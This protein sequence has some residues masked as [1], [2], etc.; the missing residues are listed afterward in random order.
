[1]NYRVLLWNM[2]AV[3]ALALGCYVHGMMSKGSHL[4]SPGLIAWMAFGG[5]SAMLAAAQLL[6]AIF[7]VVKGRPSARSWLLCGLIT[8]AVGP[9]MCG[10]ARL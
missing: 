3:V 10:V 9:G 1:M 5:Y 7:L 6:V 8:A 2:L 4:F